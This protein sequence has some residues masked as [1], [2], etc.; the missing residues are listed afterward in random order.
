[1]D[2][3]ITRCKLDYKELMIMECV[4]GG[5]RDS[6]QCS[7]LSI[8]LSIHSKRLFYSLNACAA[9]KIIRECMKTVAVFRGKGRLFLFT[10][11]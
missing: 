5:R 4:N 10:I 2:F 6:V 1:M 11:F 7:K 9:L 8:W 3:N